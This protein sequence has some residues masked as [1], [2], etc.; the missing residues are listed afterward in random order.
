MENPPRDENRLEVERV[1]FR[2]AERIDAPAQRRAEREKITFRVHVEFDDAVEAYERDSDNRDDEADVEEA[3]QMVLPQKKLEKKRGE[4]RANR[5]DDAHV[6]R[7]R[8]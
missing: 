7:A 5:H 3:R 2:Y 1:D 4:H 6:R 8:I